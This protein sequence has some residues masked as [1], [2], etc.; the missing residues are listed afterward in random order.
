MV[1]ADNPDEPSAML[2]TFSAPGRG[3]R[4]AMTKAITSFVVT[5]AGSLVTTEKK[6]LRSWA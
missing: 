1:A 4:C 3:R 2:I 5:S 6:T